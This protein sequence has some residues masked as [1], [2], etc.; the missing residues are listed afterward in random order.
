[1][2][3]EESI[4]TL[5]SMG[6]ENIDDIKKALRLGKNDINEAV[7][8]LTNEHSEYHL[9]TDESVQDMSTSHVIS[10]APPPYEPLCSSQPVQTNLTQSDESMESTV[11]PTTN[12]YELESRIFTDQ[13]SIP[14]KKEE[15]LGKCLLSA[16]QL[17]EQGLCEVNDSC[18]KFIEHVLPEAFKKL[19][20]SGAVRNWGLDIQD[21]VRS[22]LHLLVNLV[23]SRLK[24]DPVPETLL[25]VLEKAFDPESEFHIKN[26]HKSTSSAH[27]LDTVFSPEQAYA[28]SRNSIEPYGWLVDLI[29]KFG[30]Q[31][32]FESIQERFKGDITGT[33][34]A[35]LLS[36]LSKCAEFLNPSKVCNT[37]SS[38][39]EFAVQYI[40]SLSD[41]DIKSKNV[42]SISELLK[43]MKL[44]CLHL[45]PHQVA[46]TNSLC[47]EVI[48]RML[49]CPH[50]NARMNGLK[51][52]MKL[53]DDSSSMRSS[54]IAIDS[55]SLLNWL[56]ENEILSIAL[57]GNIDQVQYTDKIK[58]IVEFTGHRLS[59]EELT[60]IWRMQD[61]QNAQVVDNIHSIMTA[62]SSKYNAEQFDHLLLLVQDSW[63]NSTDQM[64]KRLLYFIGRI[65]KDTSQ[66]RA[67]TKI[68][69]LLWDLAHSPSIPM[70]I[71]EL[72]LQEHFSILCEV[73]HKDQIKK[74][75]CV[76]CIENIKK[77]VSVLPSLRLLHNICKNIL[78]SGVYKQDRASLH[79]LNKNHDI[80]K[81][82]T[83]SLATCHKQAT[84]AANGSL[85]PTTLVDGRYTHEDYLNEHLS[86]LQFIL[87][88]GAQYLPWARAKDVW[89]ALISNKDACDR[90]KEVCF[91]WFTRCLQDLESDTQS[92][93]FQYKLLKLDPAL[94]TYTGFMCFKT[95]FESVNTAEHRLKRMASGLNV[96]K[97]ELNGID[98][99]WQIALSCEEHLANV[100]IEYLLEISY[101]ALVPRLK[102]DVLSLHNRFINECYKKLETVSVSLSSN[103]MV[104]AVS[105]ATKTLTAISVF[106]VAAT[107][108]H[109][110]SERFQSICRLLQIAERYISSIE[111]SHVSPRTILPHGTSFIGHPLL[112]KICMDASK[113]EHF[114]VTH[115][116]ETLGSV[117]QRI[118]Q[119]LHQNP[120]QVFLYQEDNSI[121]KNKEQ[122]LMC[123]LNIR[124]GHILTVK[125]LNSGM[126]SVSS[127]DS[128]SYSS[129]V[130]LSLLSDSA[131]AGN[132]LSYFLDQERVLPGVVM[133]AG[134]Q[135]FEKLHLLS[136]HEDPN[137]TSQVRNLLHLIP[138]DPAILDALD[139]IS[140]KKVTEIPSPSTPKS[141]PRSSPKKFTVTSPTKERCE[142]PKEVLKNLFDVS[143]QIS[144][145]KLL[146]ILEA[147]SGKLMPVAQDSNTLQSAQMFSN[148]FLSAGGLSLVL[149]V[150]QKDSI[151]ND[152]DY[153]IRQGCYLT[154]LAIARFLLCGETGLEVTSI[155]GHHSVLPSG[156][157]KLSI[158]EYCVNTGLSDD[159]S[160]AV[161]R[162]NA[163]KAIETIKLPDLLETLLNLVRLSW[164]AAAGNLLLVNCS[165]PIKEGTHSCMSRSRQSSTGSNASSGSD[166]CENLILQGGVC[167]QQQFVKEK[168]VLLSIKSLEFLITCI[169]MRTDVFSKFSSVLCISDFIIDILLCSS[170]PIVR[171]C[172]LEE[173]S[174][175]STTAVNST[176]TPR[177]YLIGVLLKARLPLWVTSSCIRGDNQ[178]LLSQCTEYFELGCRLLHG[179][180]D[181][182]QKRLHIDPKQMIEDEIAW[183]QGFSPSSSPALQPADSAL[184]AGHFRY[185]K[186][187]LTCDGVQK[188]EVG[189]ILIPD[190]LVNF[191][192]PASLRISSD[193]NHSMSSNVEDCA[194]KCSSLESRIAAYEVLVELAT[195]CP[196]NME[197]ISKRILSMH[198]TLKPELAKEYEYEPLV[199]ARA[200]CGYVGLKN[201]G[202]TCYMNSVIQ[203]LYMQPGIKEAI[204][205]VDENE[206][207]E[208]G[209]FYQFQTVFGHL[210]ESRLQY[211][212]PERFWK[213]FRLWGEPINVRE[214]QDAFEFFTH[215]ID[216]IDE[217]LIK[218]GWDPVFKPKYEGVFSDQKICQGCP[219]RYEREETFMAL[220]LPVKSQNLL[221]SL[222]QFVK[223]EL[224][225]GHNAYLCEKCHEKRNTVKRT[226]IKTLPSVLV[227]QLKRFDY[228][229]EANRSL[230][231][232]DYFKFPWKL[233]MQPYTAEGIQERE[234]MKNE[235]DCE[236]QV[237]PASTNAQKS[238]NSVYELVGVLVHSGQAN[239]GHYYSYIKERRL[240]SGVQLSKWFKFNDISVEEFE[241]NDLTIEA[242]CF[243][244]TYKAKVRDSANSY[245]EIR[246]RYWNAY[247]LFYEKVDEA[248][249]TPRT[250][251]KT[252]NKFSFRKSEELSINKTPKKQSPVHHISPHRQRDSLSQLTQLVDRGE[253]HGLFLERM[254]ARI[255]QVV[256]DEN[257]RFMHNCDIYND[258]YFLF[259]RQ[260]LF[261]NV[262]I[263]HSPK[264]SNYAVNSLLPLSVSFLLNTYLR[265]KK[266][267]SDT[268]NE[269]VDFIAKVVNH[270]QEASNWFIDFLSTDTGLSYLKTYLLD[271]P[272]REV[273]Q[274]FSRLV[275]KGISYFLLNDGEV[276]SPSLHKIIV[277]LL[278]MLNHDV[279]DNC[280][281]CSQ[282]F[283]LLSSYAQMGHKTCNHLIQNTAFQ[284]LLI[285]LLGPASADMQSPDSFPRRWT[286]MQAQ[287]FGALHI[288]MASL[289]LSC[290]LTPHRTCELEDYP[291][292]SSIFSAS[293]TFLPMPQDISDALYGPG[294]PRYLQEIV[295][296]CREVSGSISVFTDMLVQCCFCNENFS[297]SI[298]RQIMLQYSSVPSNELKNLSYL[299][300]EILA[301]EDLLQFKRVLIVID[302]IS[303]ELQPSFDGMLAI[304]RAN[305]TTDSR[306]SYQGV[307]FLVSLSIKCPSIKDYLL[308]TPNK[309]QWA[310]NW[311]KKMMSEHSYWTPSNVSVSNEDSNTKTFQRTVSAQD[312]LA[313]ATAML[314]G[315]ESPDSQ[316]DIVM[317][318]D[319]KAEETEVL[320]QEEHGEGE[321]NPKAV[322]NIERT[323]RFRRFRR[324]ARE[325]MLSID[326]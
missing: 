83:T 305:E 152:V 237:V 43:S 216:Q 125:C 115:S 128:K 138:T 46:L 199:A 232:D 268:M 248:A 238:G 72:A 196:E 86:F 300:L 191:L 286:P 39:M 189:K 173:F 50:F 290:D 321:G 36:P 75:Y 171:Q 103:A 157:G 274:V 135:V 124:D 228:D 45:W 147:L 55:E 29:N 154:A 27:W 258:S 155:F 48:L 293:E 243:G 2:D 180:T 139:S 241:M 269:L 85:K 263:V 100:A 84:E 9:G 47:L 275:Q 213:C 62:A 267:S 197:N 5:L 159:L 79:E 25:H 325:K 217:Y 220:N 194:P 119:Y 178:R 309:W 31:G 304:I 284:K 185:V 143:Y 244:G 52:V 182:D 273:R 235:S 198:H 168:D 70:N 314:D 93:L 281:S 303:S 272:C 203:Q 67:S 188:E 142:S 116:N 150:L 205:S 193:G 257:L 21:G 109:N 51:E 175:L 114:I 87:Q 317:D 266:R 65:G 11:F 144:H 22:M 165:L 285:F 306:R 137:V 223:G 283:W 162:L 10:V 322:R 133:A 316:D 61:G 256:Q 222:D 53:I 80:I 90:D 14:F 123:Q 132:H 104:T 97:L 130:S 211:H 282:Y 201:A 246:H 320:Q 8:I 326:P 277:H 231:F 110:R 207:N 12:L 234:T 106:E 236:D 294:A 265:Y 310:V 161:K 35:A 292:R 233:D 249:R 59:L 122:Q 319:E 307:K 118:A 60:K 195:G 186:T 208:D 239:A 3:H 270:C 324:V 117:K 170:S 99:L 13:W 251:R 214:Q 120:S 6:F 278:D 192:F 212:A 17:A 20:T 57:E 153:D 140:A 279:P 297:T 1:M 15:S 34:M 301:M 102:K 172:A 141:S 89:D 146:Y 250:P 224:L 108:T 302:G 92:M 253:R 163:V 77:S 240:D 169:K 230:K 252:P 148:D 23:T 32:G 200:S 69:D 184:M 271:C 164:A 88:D 247:M 26:K 54:K 126:S 19:L 81:L 209:L 145:F 24:S 229:W 204:L 226:C 113:E 254:P 218:N 318:V 158:I 219:H 95:Y 18:R 313:E 174:K 308:Q 71:V 206:P 131:S 202:A 30:Q 221:D 82:M 41:N 210:L 298:I 56:A 66:G 91:E 176:I 190:L 28:L 78:K 312:T 101:H 37:L 98:F 280:K 295:S 40:K 64:K 288:T 58:G 183:L 4:A 73:S 166:S 299:L 187:L 262:N 49:K 276:T 38:C 315:L 289:V 68:V 261:A 127:Q 136:T 177:D 255:Q 181:F 149:K 63:E 260:L 151:P 167:A 311:L 287:E 134:G 121:P 245:P 74:Q 242:E 179:L 264:F 227:I 296:A 160:S 291:E 111:E 112:L 105:N 225:E 96:E 215:L 94:L 76:K 7:S 44:L 107:P 33:G 259:I 129:Y 323:N 16:T 156:S 42:C